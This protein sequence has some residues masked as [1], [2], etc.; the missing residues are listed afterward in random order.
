MAAAKVLVGAPAGA[1]AKALAIAPTTATATV[2]ARTIAIGTAIA[3]GHD[4]DY[5]SHATK[6]KIIKLNITIN[7]TFGTA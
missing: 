3:T 1:M 4:Y 5:G 6:F 2:V 7:V